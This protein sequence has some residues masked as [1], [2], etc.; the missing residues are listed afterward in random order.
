[1]SLNLA[2]S[3][4]QKQIF[5]AFVHQHCKT[6]SKLKMSAYKPQNDYSIFVFTLKKKPVRSVCLPSILSTS[7]CNWFGHQPSFLQ[8][9]KSSTQAFANELS[10]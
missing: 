10:I 5:V 9:F 4:I 3:R 7:S 8:Y 1:M 2:K 6:W